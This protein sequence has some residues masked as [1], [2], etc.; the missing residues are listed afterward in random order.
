MMKTGEEMTHCPHCG[1]RLYVIDSRVR[2]N[3]RLKCDVRV[4]NK[5]CPKCRGDQGK[6]KF[7]VEIPRDEFRKLMALRVMRKAIKSEPVKGEK[8]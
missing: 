6:Y 5:R 2:E 7:T 1:S 8:F 3:P 4:R